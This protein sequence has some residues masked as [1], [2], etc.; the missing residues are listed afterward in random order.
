MNFYFCRYYFFLMLKCRFYVWYVYAGE[1][2][3]IS[4]VLFNKRILFIIISRNR[5]KSMVFKVKTK[6]IFFKEG[7]RDKVFNLVLYNKS[8]SFIKEVEIEIINIDKNEK[9]STKDKFKGI[10]LFKERMSDL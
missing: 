3:C 1:W 4:Y 10:S 8:D 9:G 7:K 2:K 5:T 6:L